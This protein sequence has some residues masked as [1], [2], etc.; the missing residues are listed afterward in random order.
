MFAIDEKERRIAAYAAARERYNITTELINEAQRRVSAVSW[1]YIAGATESET[2]LKRNRM[3]ID[4]LA[5]RPR[6]MRNVAGTDASTEFLGRRQRLPVML[7][8]V[9]GLHTFS[10]GGA[11][12]PARAAREFGVDF[13]Q[14][15]VTEPD[16]DVVSA[17]AGDHWLFQLYVFGD[18]GWIEDYLR[19]A[20]DLGVKGFCITVDSD[21][22]S[23]RERNLIRHVDARA[24][25]SRGRGDPKWRQEFDWAVFDKIRAL[26]DIPMMLKGI[27]RPEDAALCAEHGVD[28]VY[29]SNHGGRQLD[30]GQ[31]TIDVLPEIVDAVAGRAKIV[32]DGGFLRGT[33]VLKAIILG[34]DMV[35]LGKLQAMA[36]GAAGEAGVHRMLEILEDEITIDMKLMG[37]NTLAELDVSY[38]TQAQPTE[39]PSVFSTFPLLKYWGMKGKEEL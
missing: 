2:S 8:P 30:H 12:L 26:S 21:H 39:A 38:I 22:Y 33:D 18:L 16:M 23:R 28:V 20:I 19:S 37:V 29:I 36:V 4:S 27:M 24:S 5:L 34:A 13:M 9:G 11:A 14:S 3:G 25:N 6:V 35:A 1:D 15:S 31:G 10:D 7:A 17:A 32:I